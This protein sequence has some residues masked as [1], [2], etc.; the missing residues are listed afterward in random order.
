ML[1]SPGVQRRLRKYLGMFIE[2]LGSPEGVRDSE[3]RR[4]RSMVFREAFLEEVL[5]PENVEEFRR[6][7]IGVVKR[8]WAFSWPAVRHRRVILERVSRYPQGF[9]EAFRVLFY[10]SGPLRDRFDYA[11]ERLRGTGIGSSSLTEIMCYAFPDRYV[12]WNSVVVD[13]LRELGLIDEVYRRLGRTKLQDIDG[14]DYETILGFF[15]ELRDMVE[16]L[17]SSETRASTPIDFVFIDHF[18]YF[19]YKR[20]RSKQKYNPYLLQSLSSLGPRELLL[21]LGRFVARCAKAVSPAGVSKESVM[22]CL[23]ALLED[24]GLGGKVSVLATHKKPLLVNDLRRLGLIEAGDA[25]A[26]DW[27]SGRDAHP[28]PLF[29]R[30]LDAIDYCTKQ[31]K[32]HGDEQS[33]CEHECA[34]LG[35]S[36]VV[37]SLVAGISVGSRGL[38]EVLARLYW[39]ESVEAVVYWL[40]SEIDA[41]SERIE[42]MVTSMRDL[43]AESISKAKSA[44]LSGLVPVLYVPLDLDVETSGS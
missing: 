30:V 18:L 14:K 12:L 23:R 36:L 2:Y 7:F 8:L 4:Q 13:A 20:A 29:W 26:E 28:S 41:S 33:R 5:E 37:V 32:L 39:G 27:P 3:R 10:G 6:R 15:S 40:S 22:E 17:V 19:A 11:R 21:V 35:G 1:Q 34:L 24:M 44:V 25:S 31:C 9:Q 16:E 43:V 42:N 38:Q